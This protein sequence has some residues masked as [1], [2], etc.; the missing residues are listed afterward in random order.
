MWLHSTF[1]E[2]KDSIYQ[3]IPKERRLSFE[4]GIFNV[5]TKMY[6]VP[7]RSVSASERVGLD[8]LADFLE[9]LLELGSIL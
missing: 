6:K 1:K 2:L 7:E 5:I 4:R 8:E 9:D 3:N